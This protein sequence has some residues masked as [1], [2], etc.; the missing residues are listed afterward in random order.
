[1]VSHCSLFRFSIKVTD[2]IHTILAGYEKIVKGHV[3]SSLW[4]KYSEHM[5]I[6]ANEF[7]LTRLI[8][9][10]QKTVPCDLCKEVL[11]VVDQI[12]KDNATE[13]RFKM[14]PATVRSPQRS[15]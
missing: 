6:V 2:L 9:W 14:L 3:L 11:M 12:L 8:V 13:V 7:L 5:R 10:F 4:S 15:L 1:M